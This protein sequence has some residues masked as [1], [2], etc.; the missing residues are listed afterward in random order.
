M[1][2]YVLWLLVFSSPSS[3]L[4]HLPLLPPFF[5]LPPFPCPPF[6]TLYISF[7]P[8]SPLFPSPLPPLPPS[9]SLSRLGDQV[10]SVNGISLLSVTHFDAVQVLKDTGRHVSLVSWKL[11]WGWWLQVVKS[12]PSS[13]RNSWYTVRQTHL[14]IALIVP[15][16]H[17]TFCCLHN[18]SME[19]QATCTL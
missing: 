16:P 14:Y 13:S 5:P 1:Y 10:V 4:F 9:S 18:C 6:P 19:K 15:S 11:T 2:M 12:K 7:P 3:T 17:P 8:P